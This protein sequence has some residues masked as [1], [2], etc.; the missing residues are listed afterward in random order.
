MN[1]ILFNVHDDERFSD[2]R[3][4]GELSRKLLQT[5][6]YLSFPRLYLLVKLALLLPV[7]TSTVEK[8]FSAMK[9]IKTSLRNRISDEF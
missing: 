4:I 9:I 1:L 8:V 5:K 3:G 7:S 6:K 2:L